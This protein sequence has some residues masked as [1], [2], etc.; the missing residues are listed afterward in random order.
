MAAAR[1]AERREAYKFVNDAKPLAGGA[2][3]RITQTASNP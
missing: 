1:F 3:K 2:V